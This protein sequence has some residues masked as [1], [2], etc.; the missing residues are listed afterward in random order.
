MTSYTQSEPGPETRRLPR[1]WGHLALNVAFW[2]GFY[3]I[4][5]AARGLADR[6]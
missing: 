5:Q 2:L 4:Y 3:V 6:T 1:G